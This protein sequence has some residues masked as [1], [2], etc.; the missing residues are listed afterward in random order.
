LPLIAKPLAGDNDLA[1]ARKL[2]A[3]ALQK[4]IADVGGQAGTSFDR[5]AQDRFRIQLVYILSAWPGAAHESESQLV[6]CNLN[7]R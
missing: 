3:V 1:F 7:A 6:V 2:P 4:S 5:P